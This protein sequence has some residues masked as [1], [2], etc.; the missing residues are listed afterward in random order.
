MVIQESEGVVIQCRQM[1]IQYLTS[2]DVHMGGT[3]LYCMYCPHRHVN[4][5]LFMLIARYANVPSVSVY[6]AHSSV[7]SIV[8]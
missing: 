5:Y 6:L 4:S 7:S 1:I 2:V 8:D 3:D